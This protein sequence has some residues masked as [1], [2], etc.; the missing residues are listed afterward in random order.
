MI[1]FDVLI[2]IISDILISIGR[3][4]YIY[5]IYNP[6]ITLLIIINNYLIISYYITFF[7]LLLLINLLLF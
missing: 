6:Y 7:L 1:L 3:L 5:N 4:F 2:E